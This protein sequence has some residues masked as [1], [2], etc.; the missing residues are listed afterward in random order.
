[1]G[2]AMKRFKE[3]FPGVDGL[4]SQ[5]E[6]MAYLQEKALRELSSCQKRVSW[7]RANQRH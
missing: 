3:M 2:S 1:M 5:D 7:R 6:F 4:L